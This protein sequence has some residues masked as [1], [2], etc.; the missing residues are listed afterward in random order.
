MNKAI[1]IT[2]IPGTRKTTVCDAVEK[3]AVRAGKKVDMINYGACAV[4]T[5]APIKTV[6]NAEGKQEEAAK[7]VLKTLGQ[8]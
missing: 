1:I 6:I 7:D 2:G 3:L 5:G 4:F 8:I